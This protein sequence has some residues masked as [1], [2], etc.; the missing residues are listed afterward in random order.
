MIHKRYIFIT[1]ALTTGTKYAY[2]TWNVDSR[3]LERIHPE[4][5]FL[6]VGRDGYTSRKVS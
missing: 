1:S 6:P 2:Y 4:R 5:G 3:R